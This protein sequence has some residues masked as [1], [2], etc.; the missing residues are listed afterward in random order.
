MTLL[1]THDD[2]T[3]VWEMSGLFVNQKI[4]TCI[5]VLKPWNSPE[6]VMEQ[7]EIKVILYYIGIILKDLIQVLNNS[8]NNN[9]TRFSKYW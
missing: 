4:Q 7:N 2:Y 1:S 3:S 5:R 9:S 8:L 6:Q